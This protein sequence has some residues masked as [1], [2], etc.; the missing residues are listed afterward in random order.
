MASER[1]TESLLAPTVQTAGLLAVVA[2]VLG[3]CW[4]ALVKVRDKDELECSVTDL[5]IDEVL[6]DEPQ[7]RLV[8]RE[9]PPLLDQSPLD[10]STPE[11]SR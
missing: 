4:Y 1:R 10:G 3:F 9:R 7:P 2:L 11:V 6:R 5:L 8:N